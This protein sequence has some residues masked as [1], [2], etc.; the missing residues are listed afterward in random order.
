V[1]YQAGYS[2][3][4]G[5]ANTFVGYQAG[6]NTNRTDSVSGRNVFIGE[7]AGFANTTGRFNSYLG[8]YAGSA[9]TTGSSN[10]IIGR[11]D[12]NLNGLDIRTASNY[13]VLSDGDGNPREYFDGS[14]NRNSYCQGTSAGVKPAYD[15]R[16]WVN[17]N[18]TGTVAINAS[19]NVSSITDNGTGDYTVNFSTAMPDA[20]YM[21]VASCSIVSGNVMI[22]NVN[23]TA[24]QAISTPTTSACRV[25]TTNRAAG[26]AADPT[27]VDVA[28]FR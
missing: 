7:A 8:H 9:I 26:N 24:G 6:Y 5:F 10:T 4:T 11:Y 1:G 20:N 17:F 27:Y 18:G 25:A 13:I 23:S 12:G 14:G 28:I 22:V 21:P 19:G 15:C 3:T 2:N 16:S